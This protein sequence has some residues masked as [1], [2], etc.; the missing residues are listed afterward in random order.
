MLLHHF[1][2]LMTYPSFTK[3]PEKLKFRALLSDAIIN[4]FVN[5]ELDKQLRHDYLRN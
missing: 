4:T 1:E 3:C 5:E 2:D